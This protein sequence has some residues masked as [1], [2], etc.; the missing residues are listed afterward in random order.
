M[1]LGV[2]FSG[3][4]ISFIFGLSFLFTKNSLAYVPVYT[5]LSYRF[6]IAS[7]SMI[8]LLFFKVIRLE[9]KP[10]WKIWKVAIFQPI[11]YFIFETNGLK[12][13]S[14]SEAG[15]LIAMIPIVVVV[16]SPLLLK[17]KIRWY[18]I[19]FA[20][21]SFFG[22]VL[23]V[24]FGEKVSGALLGKLLILGAVFSAAMYNILSRKLSEEFRPQEITFF[25]M[26][27][28]F[29]FFTFLSLITGQF[30]INLAKPVLIGTLYLGILSSTVAF[31]LVNFMLS[32]V[33]PTVSTLFS[34][35]TTIVSVLAGSFI[36]HETIKPLQVFGM[37]L[38]LSAL[39]G[40]SY[41][42][43]KR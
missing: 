7:L 20:F 11:L 27:T 37:V 21:L 41:L 22:V 25:M 8:V 12:Y 32:K 23:I 24:G 34:N 31:F 5:F 4:A 36:R 2:L 16:L 33:S 39:I 28:G 38:I 30:T 3:L 1:S 29:V 17:E 10:Y 43:T 35:L 18:K 42:S 19:F 6:F 15:M 40:N 14:S 13:A 9:K 26:I